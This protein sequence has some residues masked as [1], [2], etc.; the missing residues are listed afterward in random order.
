LEVLVAV[1]LQQLVVNLQVIM[2]EQE[3]LVLLIQLQIQMFQSLVVA[4]EVVM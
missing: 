1:E 2:V 3:E 4:V